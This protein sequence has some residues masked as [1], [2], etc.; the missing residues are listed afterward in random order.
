MKAL[1]FFFGSKVLAKVNLSLDRQ[2][3]GLNSYLPPTFVGG[4]Y[5]TKVEDNKNLFQS[6]YYINLKFHSAVA[7]E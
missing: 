1:Y 2:M 6:S 3:D 4:K 5:K 7:R